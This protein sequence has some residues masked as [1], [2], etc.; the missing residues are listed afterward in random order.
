VVGTLAG[1]LFGVG[2]AMNLERVV[3]LIEGVF[4]FK[5]LPPSVY[6]IDKLPSHVEPLTVLIIVAFS[7]GVSFLATLY[8]SWQAARMRPV[9]SLRYE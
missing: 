8:P 9:D 5:I 6:Y 1:A 2:V 4:H 7:L 3:S